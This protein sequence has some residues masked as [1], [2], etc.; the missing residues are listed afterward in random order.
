MENTVSNTSTLPT[1]L[2]LEGYEA[3]TDVYAKPVLSVYGSVKTYTNSGSGTAAENTPGTGAK[4]K[5]P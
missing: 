3:K 1:G 4:S 5:H 2:A